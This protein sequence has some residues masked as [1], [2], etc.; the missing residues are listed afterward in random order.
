LTLL[1]LVGSN[2][3][4]IKV[5]KLWIDEYVI[6]RSKI[7]QKTTLSSVNKLDDIPPNDMEKVNK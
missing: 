6:Y 2:A 7:V 5:V 3:N 4:M 1:K